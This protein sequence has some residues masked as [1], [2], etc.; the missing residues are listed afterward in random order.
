MLGQEARAD[1]RRHDDD[2]VLE[3]DGIA[4]TIG[5]MPIL[6]DLQQ[7]VV[8]IRMGLFDFVEQNDGIRI[9]LYTLG[10]LAAFL[11]ADIPWR[12]SDQL[13]HRMLFHELGHVEADQRF[14]AAEQE[15]SQRPRHF[16]LSDT[17]GAEE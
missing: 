13:R 1:V 2:G 16:R 11:I 5:Q 17:G 7:D 8:H 3:I 14:F 4:E 6:E 12:R 10:K 15:L 9:P